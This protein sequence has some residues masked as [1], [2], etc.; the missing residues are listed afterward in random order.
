M[1]TKLPKSASR[2]GFARDPLEFRQPD[3]PDFEKK[4]PRGGKG[5]P[6]GG[7]F[8]RKGDTGEDVKGVQ[9]ALGVKRDGKMGRLTVAAVRDFQ[10]EHGLQVDGII[11]RQTA[12]ALLGSSTS[13][14]PGKLGPRQRNRLSKLRSSPGRVRLQAELEERSFAGF[15]KGAAGAASSSFSSFKD[16]DPRLHPRNPLGQFTEVVGNLRPGGA[17][18]LPDGIEVRR[19][20]RDDFEV[21]SPNGKPY[22]VGANK[23]PG[24]AA[25]SA[26]LHSAASTD[27][28]SFGGS[29]KHGS[30][31][32]AKKAT[33]GTSGGKGKFESGQIVSVSGHGLARVRKMTDD[34][35][36]EVESMTISREGPKK[37]IRRWAPGAVDPYDGPTEGAG[38]LRGLDEPDGGD[39]VKAPQSSMVGR[40]LKKKEGGTPPKPEGGGERSTFDLTDAVF[41][42]GRGKETD[43]LRKRK[44]KDGFVIETPDG[45]ELGFIRKNPD[46]RRARDKWEV[47]VYRADGTVQTLVG[48]DRIQRDAIAHLGVMLRKPEGL[49]VRRRTPKRPGSSKLD[50]ETRRISPKGQGLPPRGPDVPPDKPKPRGS[51]TKTAV[52]SGHRWT[53]AIKSFQHSGP[54]GDAKLKAEQPELHQALSSIPVGDT[55]MFSGVPVTRQS[56]DRWSVK[57]DDN[58]ASPWVALQSIQSVLGV[59]RLG[60]ERGG[61]SSTPGQ[62]RGYIKRQ[63]TNAE[64]RLARAKTDGERNTAQKALDRWKASLER[65]DAGGSTGGGTKPSGDRD[66]FRAGGSDLR[67]WAEAGDPKA[68]AEIARRKAKKAGKRGRPEAPVGAA[69]SSKPSGPS[70][71]ST[72]E[73]AEREREA[74]LAVA[75]IAD[76][77]PQR[78]AN[79]TRG[80][81]SKDPEERDRVARNILRLYG[82]DAK[83]G[84]LSRPD[85]RPPAGRPENSPGFGRPPLNRGNQGS[86]EGDPGEGSTIDKAMKALEMGKPKAIE[87]VRV[88]KTNDAVSFHF[89]IQR[90]DEWVNVGR[91]PIARAAIA[92]E[93]K[94]RRPIRGGAPLPQRNFEQPPGTELGGHPLSRGVFAEWEERLARRLGRWLAS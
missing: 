79:L 89:E 1:A 15:A 35:K 28:K 93:A 92:R 69:K 80:L 19:N 44:T 8:I 49:H 41:D 67:A 36:V 58:L 22:D 56:K 13:R 73:Q 55:Q 47:G 78:H 51:K 32:D 18:K 45:W 83:P 12:A 39:V 68:R 26:L 60:R 50:V 85:A 66:Y 40:G 54:G 72:P 29:T 30:I 64:K 6:E 11:G 71:R 90:G 76:S 63:I 5:S 59:D 21:L 16:W 46:S 7:R 38:S 25:R 42:L 17:V 48:G 10:R 3:D 88:R 62:Q 91:G 65:F 75:K 86:T 82:D 2:P 61:G 31:G 84:D 24:S 4:H 77:D 87:G 9:R 57:G 70:K 43:L 33:G 53:D 52:V 81:Q 14:A 23:T 20:Q 74:L 37:T 27:E 94:K 34:G